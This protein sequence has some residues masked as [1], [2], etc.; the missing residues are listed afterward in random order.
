M[1]W[2]CLCINHLDFALIQL[3][4]GSWETGVQILRVTMARNVRQ[5]IVDS[6]GPHLL[7]TPPHSVALYARVR[8]LLKLRAQGHY[9]K[10]GGAL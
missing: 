10:G 8:A 5:C 2:R 7:F 6:A 4:P 1:K 3:A 9:G